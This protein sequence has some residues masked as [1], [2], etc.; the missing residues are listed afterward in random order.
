M[1]MMM[2]G[3]DLSDDIDDDSGDSYDLITFWR[4]YEPAATSDGVSLNLI[5]T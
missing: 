5:A 2:I 3:G 1:M 4:T